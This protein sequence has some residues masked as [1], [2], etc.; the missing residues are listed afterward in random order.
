MNLIRQSSDVIQATAP[1]KLNLF[2]EVLNRRP[3]G[4]HELETVMI[5]TQ[6]CDRLTFRRTQTGDIS[7]TLGNDSTA[8]DLNDV[9][10]NESNLIVRAARALQTAAN[11]TSGGPH[12]TAEAHPAAGRTGWRIQRRRHHS[13]GTGMNCGTAASRRANCTTWPPRW[14]VI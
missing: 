3:D 2:L 6:L 11:T 8:Q 5:R 9:P 1:A 10:L 14:A 13:A 7:L 12:C 4:F